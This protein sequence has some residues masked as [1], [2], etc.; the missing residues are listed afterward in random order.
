M[1][2]ENP[3]TA[4][5]YATLQPC[6]LTP[7]A[8]SAPPPTHPCLPTPPLTLA[9]YQISYQASDSGNYALH[10]WMEEGSLGPNGERSYLPGSPFTVSVRANANDQVTHDKVVDVSG[11]QP[12]DYK[13]DKATYEEVRGRPPR[14]S[15]DCLCGTRGTSPAHGP[16]QR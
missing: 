14:E 16:N 15:D 9:H 8:Y 6:L 4:Y 1:P 13:F 2:N 7:S 3:L 10:V 12:G 5:P 11:I